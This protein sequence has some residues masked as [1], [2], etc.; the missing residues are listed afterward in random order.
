MAKQI[1]I[2]LDFKE[3]F[4]IELNKGETSVVCIPSEVEDYHVKG[5]S[6]TRQP[7][8]PMDKTSDTK[9]LGRRETQLKHYYS[10]I[11]EKVGDADEL[12]VFGPAEAKKGLEKA[13]A[14]EKAFQ[15]R[16]LS[17]ET[18]DSMTQNQMVARVRDFFRQ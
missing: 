2:W 6:R 9:Y 4:V 12:F 14:S 13:I 11:M 5:G 7:W 3:A 8:G 15:P 17:M 16:L 10:R 18:A 1:G